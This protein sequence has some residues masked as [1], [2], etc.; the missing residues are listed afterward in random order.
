MFP[1]FRGYCKPPWR[2]SSACL[3]P[4][5]QHWMPAASPDQKAGWAAS[6]PGPA[7]PAERLQ[8][9]ESLDAKCHQSPW[10]EPWVTWVT[11]GQKRD[12]SNNA[13]NFAGVFSSLSDKHTF[14]TFCWDFTNTIIQTSCKK[15]FTFYYGAFL[16]RNLPRC[17][18]RARHNKE[19]A[20]SLISPK[21]CC[22]AQMWTAVNRP[23]HE[24][25][26]LV[27]SGARFQ[28]LPKASKSQHE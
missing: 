19:A 23:T 13:R 9:D 8:K 22:C 4:R 12:K 27:S 21:C 24:K 26:S 15:V 1:T 25:W 20:L 28:I 2:I 18:W 5:C 7:E 17:R 6:R 10:S 3:A 14:N 11:K 16:R